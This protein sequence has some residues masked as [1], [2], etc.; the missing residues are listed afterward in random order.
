M[1]RFGPFDRLT[2]TTSNQEQSLPVRRCAE[3]RSVKIAILDFVAQVSKA[4][5]EPTERKTFAIL[6]VRT[7]V[8]W[9]SVPRQSQS[10]HSQRGT[11]GPQSA[12]SRT[13]SRQMIRGL[14][15]S[16]HL[17]TIQASDLIDFSTGFPPF[18]REK[19]LQSGLAH[20]RPTGFP[21]VSL[22][23]SVRQ[24]SSSAWLVAG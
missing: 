2:I 17:Q 8:A 7:S 6:R 12:N 14:T 18:A 19:C 13:F 4:T 22:R 11:S 5:S 9:P 1:R 24:T 23:R 20:R 16:A 10:R 3:V 15:C 21:R